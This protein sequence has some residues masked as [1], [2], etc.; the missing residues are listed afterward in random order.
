M[1]KIF[2]GLLAG[3]IALAPVVA[4]ADSTIN[5]LSA[6]TA[7]GGTEQIPMFQ[8]SNPAVTTT[9][10][11]INT[12]VVPFPGYITS[13]WYYPFPT[14]V[15][16]TGSTTVASQIYC[17][18]VYFPI[19]V[20]FG[21]I[22]FNVV[23]PSSSGNAQ[24]AFYTNALQHPGALINSSA[25]I[26]TG[27]SGLKS[28]A[29]GGNISVGPGTT[30]GPAIWQCQN[31]DNATHALSGYSPTVGTMT[32][33]MGAPTQGAL[34]PASAI[35][36]ISCSGANCNGGSSTYNTWPASLAG[37]TWT[38]NNGTSRAY[39]VMFQVVSSP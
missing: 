12:F 32:L 39:L 10:S 23:T 31:S 34:T 22:G 14:A 16:I 37:S 5:G 11:A 4:F 28:G 25:S 27:T 9:P 7:L 36:N 30:N 20:T 3:W 13:N 29:L 24:I 19:P 17:R 1:K 21:T 26:A 33:Y 18:F 15:T 6:G 38:Y 8:G 2:V 35:D